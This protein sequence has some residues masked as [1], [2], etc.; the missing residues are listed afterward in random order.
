[1]RVSLIRAKYHSVWEPLNLMYLSAYAKEHYKK[2]PL[3]ISIKDGYFYDVD[4]IIDQCS[5]SDVV[6][7]SGT[8]PQ[9][10]GMLELAKLI[11]AENSKVKTVLGGFGPSLEP[12]KCLNNDFVDQ[13]VVGEGERA[14][15][16]ILNG[17]KGRIVNCS[18]IADIDSIPFPD[19][20][21]LDLEK[22]ISIAK[23]EEG[24]RVTSVLANRGCP[25]N[26]SFCVEG[27]FGGIWGEVSLT[28]HGPIW[29]S[30]K[31]LRTRAPKNVVNEMFLVKKRYDI[32]FFKFSDAELNPSKQFI[33]DLCKEMVSKKWETPWGANFRVD[34]MDE[35]VCQWLTKAHCTE[36]WFGVE[37]GS[38]KVLENTKKGI[39]IGMIRT[40]FAVT[41][42]YGLLR[43]AYFLLGTPLE[44][45]DTIKETEALIDEIDPYIVSFSIL[46]PYPGTSYWS[47]K[48]KDI[49]WSIVDEYSNS[50]WASNYLSNEQLRS[51]QKRLMDKYKSK[52]A[53]IMRKKKA[54]GVI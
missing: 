7:I 28:D 48:F 34:K 6:G 1:M 22:Y 50:I 41:K 13:V 36:T 25:F 26:C 42:K 23:R 17:K 16:D 2:E 32:E 30:K 46:A 4:R 40:A 31:K 39:T 10:N 3:D 8:T 44:S 29:K 12:E 5:G 35:E 20:E 15:L 11:K 45:F 14:F 21:A 18:P 54:L 24:R 47:S 52:L 38:P 49:D 51:E 33:I 37:S 43:R 9:L 27:E 53:L 19:R